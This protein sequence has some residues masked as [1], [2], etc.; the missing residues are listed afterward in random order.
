MSN[1]IVRV[2]ED[3]G[4]DVSWNMFTPQSDIQQVYKQGDS[5]FAPIQWETALLCNNVS[6][7]F[8]TNLES[9]LYKEEYYYTCTG[10]V[11]VL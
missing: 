1:L 9:A 3:V 11:Q 10:P 8:R 6:N 4:C 2:F 7:W 5:R